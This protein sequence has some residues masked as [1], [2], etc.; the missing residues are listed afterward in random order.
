MRRRPTPGR[1]TARR[2][3][4]AGRDR[5]GRCASSPSASRQRR[6]PATASRPGR[7]AS[8]SAR[9]A[10]WRA[11]TAPASCCWPTTG[12]TRPR[13][14]CCRPARRR[15][16]RTG[17]DAAHASS[18]TASAGRGPG[19]TRPREAIEAYVRAPSPALRRRRQQRRR[20]ASRATAC[21]CSVWPALHRGVPRRRSRAGRRRRPR[22][23]RRSARWPSWRR[24]TSPRSRAPTGSTSRRWSALSPARRGNAL[25]AW[26]PAARRCRRPAWSTRLLA[27]LPGRRA[28]RWPVAGG[29]LRLYRGLLRFAARRFDRTVGAAG[30]DH[31]ARSIAPGRYALPGWGGALE[32]EAVDAGGVALARLAHLE[33]RPRAGGEH[34]QLRAAAT[35]AQPEEAVPGGRRAGVAAQR[36]AAL[37]RR[38][39]AVRARPR[40]RRRRDRGR[41]GSRRLALRWLPTRNPV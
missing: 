25:R 4:R 10:A 8:A 16:G 2:S 11:R 32:V 5:A 33:L 37:R 29:E 27:E 19:W 9:S 17:G 1:R 35:G 13:P 6:R 40:H 14:C 22:A 21:G 15:P 18:A 36:P 20:R 39:L 28:A 31:A 26:L 24:S 38:L 7:G 12:A 41:P 23:A 3:A 34:F 30:R